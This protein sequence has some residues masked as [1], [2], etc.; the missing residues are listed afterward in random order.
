ML[1]L[2]NSGVA[3][4]VVTVATD[5]VKGRPATVNNATITNQSAPGL[6]PAQG[7]ELVVTYIYNDPD[8]IPEDTSLSTYAWMA[9]GSTVGELVTGNTLFIPGASSLD[10]Y[11]T[12][13]ITAAESSPSDPDKAPMVESAPTL[14]PVL[15]PRSEF[16]SLYHLTNSVQRWGDAYMYCANRGERLMSIAELQELFVTYTRAKAIG[17]DS[18]DDL[19]KTYGYALSNPVWSNAPAGADNGTLN[20]RYVYLHSDGH[21]SS[22]LNTSSVPVGCAKFGTPEGLPTV[23]NVNVPDPVIGTALTATYTYNGN[24]TIPD[25]SRFQ[26]YRADD[27]N[28]TGKAAITGATA[29]TYTPVAEDAGKWLMID[30]TPASYDTVVGNVVSDT[31]NVS[32]PSAEQPF[33]SG[34]T[35]RV[36][37]GHVFRID[38]GFPSTGVAQASF[39]IQIAGNASNNSGYTWSTEHS[40]VRVDT[41]GNVTLPDEL[42]SSNNDFTIK[43]VGSNGAT[44]T[45]SFL[46][47]AWYYSVLVAASWNEV[48]DHC[49]SHGMRMP[50][51]PE[52]TDYNGN[53][54]PYS[55][56]GEWGNIGWGTVWS[57]TITQPG[58]YDTVYFVNGSIMP[59]DVNGRFTGACRRDLS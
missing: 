23:T 33:P 12:V 38:S 35:L 48:N 41:E 18:G 27:A 30:I 58:T 2:I 31:S 45:K 53:R 29:K 56:W 34:T 8:A 39:Q 57:S 25:L 6:N 50:S 59:Q 28:G 36:N 7:D 19:E 11:L 10:K 40:E 5:T 55:L 9:D 49:N 37:D 26:W 44:Y 1:A 16:E 3:Y 51:Q 24:V 42:N 15:P 47:Q 17:E 14:A 13:Q 52:L 43:A 54:R 22:N 46:I 21:E 20:H 4:A 32:V